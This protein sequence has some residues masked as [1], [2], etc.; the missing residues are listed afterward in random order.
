[1]S[2]LF[3]LGQRFGKLNVRRILKSCTNW[4]KIRYWINLIGVIF[5]Y[6]ST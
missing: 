5:Y 6:N 1:M 3:R 2:Y 4:I